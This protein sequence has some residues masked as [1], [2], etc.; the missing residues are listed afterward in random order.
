V[1]FLLQLGSQ[2]QMTVWAYYLIE[3]FNW[4][5]FDIGMSVAV[6]GAMLAFTQGF[7]TGKVIER[8]GAIRTATIGLMFGIPSYLLI[9]F[10]SSGGMIYAAVLVGG[11]SGLTFPALQGL[12]SAKVDPD[13][14]G[15]LQGAIAS[16]VSLTS[17]AGPLIMSRIFEQFAD[18]TGPYVPGAPFL[19]AV[20]LNLLGIALYFWLTRARQ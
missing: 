19:L 4:R 1:L 13:A 11:L 16:M 8:F 9:A 18:G 12:M 14:Q 15:E 10:A 2:S 7:L 3:K 17:I 5:P 6:F 20:A